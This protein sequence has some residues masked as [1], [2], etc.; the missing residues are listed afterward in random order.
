MTIAEYRALI[1]QGRPVVKRTKPKKPKAQRPD[2][3]ALAC[4]DFNLPKP[5]QEYKFHPVRKWR[6]DYYFEA[7]RRKVG[8]EVEGGIWTG[9]RHT[10]GKGFAGDM[11]K[12]NAAAAMGITILRVVP[13]DL[14]KITTFE[15]IKK[16]L[17]AR[18]Q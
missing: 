8:L 10:R 12:Y 18:H 5:I 15:L 16:T 7:N 17:Y 9:G 14:L 11:E 6:I 3:F 4:P 13:S 1:T 2:L